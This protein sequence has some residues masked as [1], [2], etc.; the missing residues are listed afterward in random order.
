MMNSDRDPKRTQALMNQLAGFAAVIGG[1]VAYFIGSNEHPEFWSRVGRIVVG[2]ML[3]V[4]FGLF[5]GVILEQ[6]RNWHFNHRFD[7]H[8]ERWP[9]FIKGLRQVG[10]GTC[11]F[12]GV[13]ITD[14]MFACDKYWE[15]LSESQRKV[16]W[17]ARNAYE[18]EQISVE[19]LRRILQEL[20]DTVQLF[21][22]ANG[23]AEELTA[24]CPFM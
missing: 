4:P 22:Q 10:L 19:E 8:F 17:N 23:A 15:N 24:S 1:T 21:R 3:G 20:S 5:L 18:D 7:R 11:R 14:G 13:A 16:F 9:E 12:C 6:H 2:A